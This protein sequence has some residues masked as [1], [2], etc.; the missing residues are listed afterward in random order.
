MKQPSMKRNFLVCLVVF[1]LSTACA[2]AQSGTTSLRG[3][4][5]DKTGALI[6]GAKVTVVSHGQSLRR[7]MQTNNSGEYEFLA[8][9]PGS[10]TLTV[11]KSGFRRFEQNN[12]ELL[13]NLPA[14]ANVTMEI[15]ATTETVEVTSE[16]LT[17]NTSDATVGNAFE[18]KEV[19]SLPFLA[20]NVV[21]L[22][23]LQ[24]GVVF[25][26]Q[27]DTDLLSMGTINSLDLR[28]GSVDGV[29]G[30]QTNV[31]VD[32]ADSNDWQNQSPFTSA[33]PVTLD[34]VQE[35][36]V[37]TTNANATDGSVG[38][39]QVTLVTKSGQNEFHGNVRWYYRTSGTAA[40]PFF[41][42]AI[43]PEIP[44]PKLQRQIPG[45][46]LGGPIRRDR[47]FFF[48]DTEERREAS[49]EPAGPRQV[50]TDAL[51]DGVLVYECADPAQCPGG[52][53]QGL[54][55]SHTI[56]AGGFGL[57]PGQ[58]QSLD[59]GCGVQTSCGVN[60]AMIAYLNL[61]P[62]GNN[63]IQGLDSGLSFTGFSF[64][65]GI[66]RRSAIHTARLDHK[67]TSDGRHSIFWR[68][69]LSDFNVAL[70]DAQFPG[71]NPASIL[72]NNSKGFSVE[73]QGQFGP[74]LINTAS[75]GL[76]RLGVESTGQTGASFGP[77]SFDTL[78]S[79]NRG[80]SH[81]VPVHKISDDVAYTH[82]SHTLQFGASVRLIHNK[83]EDFALSFPA[84]FPNNGF[85]ISL[86]DDMVVAINNGT[87]FPAVGNPTLFE[88][89]MMALT[90]SIT[91]VNA[92]FLADAKTGKILP[93]GSPELRNF[94]ETYSEGYI[95]DSWHLRRDF[96]LTLGLRYGYEAPPWEV[97]GQEVAPTTDI[98]QWF[99]QREVN[100][101][102][103]IPSDASPLLSWA[104]AGK[105][106]GGKNSWYAPN[107]KDFAPRVSLAYAPSFSSGPG[108]AVF[109]E[110]GKT[111]IRLGAGF[112]HDRI[113]Q[114]LAVDNDL[115]GSP[116]TATQ[117][118]NGSQD[119]SLATAPRF[120]GSCDATNGICT[121]LPPLSQFLQGIP[122]QATFP[123]VPGSNVSTIGFAVDPHL[124]TPYSIHFTAS[125]QRQFSR[126]FTVDVAYVGTLGRRLMGKFDYAQYL[127]LRDPQSKTDLWSA[128]RQVVKV[129]GTP[130]NPSISPTL[131]N[132]EP[133]VAGLSNISAIPFFQNILP[134][135]GTFDSAFFCDPS[136]G[137][138]TAGYQSLSP[139]QAFYAFVTQD[140][141]ASW[142]CALFPLDLAGLF[143]LPSPYNST[144][145]PQGDGLVLFDP[146]F[147]TMPGWANFGSSNYHSL[148]A[149]VRKTAG[150]AT[151]GL[152][153]VL[154]HSIDNT[155][156]AENGDLNPVG[157]T[158]NGLIQNPFNLRAG[159]G[160]SDF[161][162]RH[163]FNA[164]WVIDLPF[165]K[166]RHFAGQAGRFTDLLI[167]GWQ[168]SGLLRLRSGFPQTPGNGFNFPTNFFLT[169]PGTLA[170]PLTTH[171]VR[172]GAAGLPNLFKDA[173]AALAAIAFT[174]PGLSGSRNVFSGPAYADTDMG[175]SKAIV[176]P[177]SE[178]QRLQFRVTA[179]NVFNGVNF[180]DTESLD[181]TAPDVFGRFIATAGPRGGA[182]EIEFG[183]R[184]EF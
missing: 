60:Q 89:G 128:F 92:T 133:N 2:W 176:L 151:F 152:N 179:F 42:K 58:F 55:A 41:N 80:N 65:A 178:K 109:G 56:P 10:Y 51:R 169:T 104:P 28:E 1:L 79:F 24:P 174:A 21:N 171:V 99:R 4:V 5:L 43:S 30:N 17:L 105:A 20:R 175:L 53:V 44:R 123:F 172:N 96:T 91:Q 90:G 26:G 97:N 81:R 153:Y 173:N 67:L 8:L 118:I 59:P 63:P 164:S 144:V 36:R 27:S 181:P 74:K 71:Q 182:R 160:Q 112:F 87:T 39:P 61:F 11:E 38:G 72:L 137:V 50:A 52:T 161:D 22:L 115:N 34:S 120:S 134:N 77:R 19:K 180:A 75:Y 64:N 162:L 184:F 136:D 125:V 32:G 106:N 78:V 82:G 141:V 132:G 18:E 117:L 129:I 45:G 135:M 102:Q 170:S 3:V 29:R 177:W 116:G 126:N 165:G 163:N 130:G 103:G 150:F 15:G 94:A 85:C 37:T 121:G 157:G 40:N 12:I 46:S 88:R 168:V 9:T 127:N 122:T 101:N 31:S 139:T 66:P 167:G 111:A 158:F 68:G 16:A 119:F 140:T 107:T 154:S 49:S 138:C 47:T 69:T 93:S 62:H 7:E 100:M 131:S 155:S 73:Y 183:I 76:T 70:T 54:T 166:G 110:G 14:T 98:M 145:D 142:S 143:G 86:C 23:T 113:G 6:T 146:Q 95:Q 13:V 148:Q 108:R 48:L 84:F 156:G 83:R 35:F 114:A 159:R 147:V 33:L 57:T 25:T 124:H 149:S